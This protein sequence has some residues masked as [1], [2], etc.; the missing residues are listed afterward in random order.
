MPRTLLTPE[1][2]F[3]FHVAPESRSLI[4]GGTP[5]SGYPQVHTFTG[6]ASNSANTTT[7]NMKGKEK[8]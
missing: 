1:P 2:G 8:A 5:T 4:P 7:S 3:W 6:G